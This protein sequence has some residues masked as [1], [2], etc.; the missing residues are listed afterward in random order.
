MTRK[1]G[2]MQFA[3]PAVSLLFVVSLTILSL[4]CR[5]AAPKVQPDNF[6][7][8]EHHGRG[9]AS[10]VHSPNAIVYGAGGRMTTIDGRPLDPLNPVAPPASREPQGDG[11]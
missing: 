8:G 10:G 2:K 11:Y 7:C 1:D 4:G 5:G 3:R 6:K 9:T